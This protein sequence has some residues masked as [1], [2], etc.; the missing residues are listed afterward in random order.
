MSTPPGCEEFYAALRERTRWA[1]V[2]PALLA[3]YGTIYIVMIWG[4]SSSSHDQLLIDWGGSIGPLTTNGEWW[5]LATAMFIHSGLLHVIAVTAGLAR[6]GLLTERLVGPAAFAGV[7]ISAGLIAGLR[8]LSAHPVAVSAGADGAIAGVY[9][10]LIVMFVWGWVQSSPLTIPLATLKGMWPGAVVFL[11]YNMATEGLATESMTTG[12]AVGLVGGSFLAL[13]I[14]SHKPPVRRLCAS[15]IAAL[16]IVVAFA[17]PLR[18]MADVTREIPRVIDL[19]KRT[20]STYDAEVMR[21]RR[22]RKT[23]DALADVAD[24][25]ASEV[26]AM[27]ASLSTLTKVPSQHQ[28]MLVDAMEYLRLRE[29]SWRLRVE[30]LRAGKMP[31][32][33]RAER[34]ESEAKTIFSKVE[35]LKGEHVEQ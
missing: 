15:T 24:G 14:G 7:Y 21:F 27:R 26:H 6:V 9:G 5:R 8:D 12:L 1:L 18:G 10:L 23:A 13:R 30:G 3:A 28:P 20:A 33:Q 35:Q 31:T 25:I 22:G 32:L 29:E 4:A 11:V 16:G 17:V 34:V 2:T 19:E